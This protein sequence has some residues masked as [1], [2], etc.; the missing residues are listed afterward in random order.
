[1]DADASVVTED[2]V[3]TKDSISRGMLLFFLALIVRLSFLPLT[4]NNGTDAWARYMLAESWLEHPTQL[5]SAVWLPLHFWLLGSALW[6]WNSEF[7]ARLLTALLG[8]ATVLP[9]WGAFRKIFGLRIAFWSAVTF[10]LFGFHVGYSVTTSSEAPTIFFLAL[11][12][13][14]WVRFYSENRWA[15]AL[16]SGVS[17]SAAS[18][19]RFE[20]WLYLPVLALALFFC[21]GTAVNWPPPRSWVH[22]TEFSL[23]AA[24]GS[25]G[26]LIYSW[27]KWREPLHAADQSAW[28]SAHFNIHQPLLNRLIAVPGALFVT[29]SPLILLLVFIGFLGL[30]DHPEPL[31]IVPA[32]LAV[33]LSGTNF[34][35]SLTKNSTMARYTLMYS[36]LLIP[37]AFYGLQGLSRRWPWFQTRRTFAGVLSFFLL[38]QAGIVAGAYYA[39]PR[40]ADKLSSVSVTL[41]LDV[42][43]RDLIH[44]LDVHRSPQD[45]LIFDDFNYDAANII[46]YTRIP[47]SDYFE[48]P[49]QEDPVIVRTQLCDFIVTRRPRFLVYS[50]NGLLRHIWPI[51]NPSSILKNSSI[52]LRRQWREGDW[53]V[54]VATYQDRP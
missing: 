49:Y 22:L 30:L 41:P 35:L 38:W 39:P 51:E 14:G 3:V 33:L 48:V 28:L 23:A 20:V 46:R 4:G 19:C 42:E 34:I 21:S 13:Y 44:W 6:V 52:A 25:V 31:V 11:G 37:Y 40:I 15:W 5:P 8:A 24:P 16:L 32:V 54:Y 7:S 17:F 26:W 1:V 29:L 27:M 53:E 2:R 18:L 36:W 12:F 50:P 43:L 47:R 10:A 9:Y 45:A